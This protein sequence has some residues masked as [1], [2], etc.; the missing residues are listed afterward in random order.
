MSRLAI[1][2]LL[3]LAA[4]ERS[5]R[6]YERTKFGL[7]DA[8]DDVSRRV[9]DVLLRKDHWVGAYRQLADKYGKFPDDLE[10]TVD[11]AFN[12]EELARAS[13][14]GT[15]G[16][17][18]FNLKKMADAQKKIDQFE[19]KRKEAESAGR[20][21]VF[22]VPPVKFDRVIYH[23]LTHV[24]QQGYDAPLWFLEGMAQ[25]SGDD[26]NAICGFAVE[27]KNV[28]DIDAALTDRNDTYA[29]GHLFWKWLETRDAVQKLVELTIFQ[30]RPWKESIEEATN[31][32]WASVVATEREWSEKEVE[33]LR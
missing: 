21:M 12:G 22:K 3:G 33:K 17:I 4:D 9:A 23:E 1:L 26:P 8:R 20:Q 13:G 28:R 7:P 15:R 30:R 10:V 16:T 25:L 29:R 11:F 6:L 2:L 18:S 31:R 14:R 19:V 24:L 32:S 5:L 27:K